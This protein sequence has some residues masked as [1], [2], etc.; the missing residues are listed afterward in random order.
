MIGLL[1][2]AAGPFGKHASLFCIQDLWN[3][4]IATF[5]LSGQAICDHLLKW[6]ECL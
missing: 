5:G 1:K 6:K 4:W 3:I 2:H